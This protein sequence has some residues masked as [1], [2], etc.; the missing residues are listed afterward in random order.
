MAGSKYGDG[1]QISGSLAVSGSATFNEE[2]EDVDFRIESDNR[3]YAF[4]VDA[5]NDRV[6]LGC[7]TT[8]NHNI[9]IQHEGADGD[10]G[11]MIIRYDGAVYPDN[12]LGGIGFDSADGNR[13]SRTTEASVYVAGYASEHHSTTDKGGYLVFGTA[14]DD[15]DDDTTSTER[16]RI[17]SGGNV[18]IGST[19]PQDKL[20]VIGTTRILKNND[21]QGAKAKLILAKSR[22]T[23]A[24]PVIL[25]NGDSIGVIEFN[26]YDGDEYLTAA[27]IT[28]KVDASPG[29]GDL[30]GAIHFATTADGASEPS[31]RVVI[32]SAGNVGIGTTTINSNAAGVLTIKNGTSPSAVTSNQIYIGSKDSTGLSSN[33]ATVE[34]FLEGGPEASS[35][36]VPNM[37]HRISVWINGTEYFIYLDPA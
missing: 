32:D 29:D 2:S 14:P 6:G 33:G 36:S 25:N 22:G 34:L 1:A 10:E 31:D 20:Q 28:C 4:Y 11:I 30:A 21:S 16:M 23:E 8:P 5:A 12:I 9:E 37:S 3:P 19:D 7:F 13:P 15:Q 17:T 27:D 26:G 24:S 35:M 18:G